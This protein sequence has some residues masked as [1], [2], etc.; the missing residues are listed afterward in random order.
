MQKDELEEKDI[1][2]LAVKL[3]EQSEDLLLKWA[4]NN[5]IK[6][7]NPR[8]DLHITVVYAEGLYDIK[9]LGEI[10]PPWIIYPRKF[11]IFPNIKDDT[12][13]LV[14]KVSSYELV[15]RHF[16]LKDKFKFPW[17]FP[18][19]IPHITMSYDAGDIDPDQFDTDKIPALTI[20]EEFLE[21]QKK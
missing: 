19:Y 20:I 15:Y 18:D 14:L 10:D 16:K 11:A 21:N 5:N 3:D 7:I 4:E 12:N 13:C 1:T 6:N 8:D 2:F 9:P 17:K